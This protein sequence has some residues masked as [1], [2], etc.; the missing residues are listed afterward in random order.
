MVL[1]MFCLAL[2][3]SAQNINLQLSH[4][5]VKNAMELLKNQYGYSF[6]FESADVDTKKIITVNVRNRSIE[7]AIQ[8]ILKGQDLTYEIRSKNIIIKKNLPLT[9]SGDQN[10]K[11]ITGIVRD[12]NGT[13]VIGANV[14]EKGTTNGII[15]DM[16]GYFS[17]KVSEGSSLQVSYIGYLTQEIRIN[18]Q[19]NISISLKEDS[20]TLDEVVVIGYG[21]VSKRELTSAVSHVSSK[22]F[23]NIGS[24]NPVMQIQGKVAGVSINNTSSADPNSTATIQ[25]R[26]VTSRQ[27]DA[28]GPLI[29]IDGIPGG[30]LLNINE[31]DIESI[32]V[33]KDGAA[34]AIY[35][36]RGSNGVI[37]ITTKKGQRDGTFRTTYTGYLSMDKAKKQLKVLSADEF[38]KHMPERGSDFGADTDWTEELLRTGYTH[39]HTIQVSGGT[40]KNNYRAT[41]DVK[42]GKGIDIR[43]TRKEIGARLSVDHSGKNDLY[44]FTFNVAPRKIDYDNSDYAMFAQ[45]LT[46]NPT[47]PVINPDNPKYFYETTGWE[48]ENPVEK[49]K[50][51]KN[52]GV[53]KYLDW[54]GT[55][56]LN[57]LPLFTP[58]KNHTLT[59]QITLAQQIN[60]DDRYWY[61]PSTST[62]AIKTGRKGEARQ[63]R[64]K[65]VQESLEWLA[66]YAFDHNGH[67]LKA[68]AGYSYQYFQ[69][70]RLQAENSDFTSDELLYNKLDNGTYNKEAV[71]RLGMLSEKNDSKLIAFFGRISYDYEGKYLA[72]ASLRYE[73]SSKF[74]SNNKWGYFPAVSAGWRISEEW[75][76][77]DIEWISDLKI[78]ADYGVTGNQNFDN[79]RSLATYGGAGQAYYDGRYYQGWAPDRNTNPNL[80]WE[81]GKNWNIGLDFSLFKNI[82]AGSFNYFNRTQQ[83]LLGDYNVPLPPHIATQ[84][85]VNV[86]SMRNQG[87]EL[88][89]NIQ[90]VNTRDFTYNIGL[91][92][93]TTNNKFVSFS[94]DIYTG[95]N[96]Y[97]Q[98][99]FPAPGS[100]GSVQRIEEGK[101]IGTFYTFEYAGV[102]ETGNWMVYNKNG[103]KIP[104]SEGTDDDKRAVGNG[105]PKLTMSLNNSFRYKDFDLTLF[106]RG[107]FGYQVYDIHNFYWGLQSAAP[108][109]NVLESAYKE[110]AHIVQGMNQH[111]SYFV[112][113]ADY[114]K[115]DVATIGYTWKSDSKWIDGF[116]VYFTGRNLITFT[117][118]KGVDPDIF[119]VNGLQPGIPSDKKGY[120][121]STRQYLLG[122]QLNF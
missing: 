78:R 102:D 110:N 85:F 19:D 65:N 64:R 42:D 104:I 30:N 41:V 28:L 38:R 117:G 6:V 80:K 89:I 113:N 26:G 21:T 77:K 75:F 52:N 8:Q 94:N 79:Y 118:Y 70:T 32:D 3:I 18:G 99:G 100:P 39:N 115:L 83:D 55:F 35:G 92:A 23:L 121:P 36:T 63:D 93:S 66:N 71:G 112:K 7:D 59:T 60:D 33:L 105:L 69:Y 5:T 106:F 57:L 86:G 96:Y 98:D 48:A 97:W 84:T 45:A 50:L 14:V 120:Y 46:L 2:T 17:I 114:L 68:M 16:N 119:P 116:R 101:R 22:D 62:L 9:T 87:F 103:E 54:D 95:Q 74:G 109:L 1:G 51:E 4:S 107:N 58:D 73:G 10:K 82:L 24:T 43:S 11:T 108:K 67:N 20:Q 61:R 76:M 40:A 37:I 90:A 29:V 111:N 34:S 25:V 88:D 122:L 27:K 81:K 13:P 91:I 49:L 56:K 31:N 12:D 15:T 72:T 47:M 53:L 44:K